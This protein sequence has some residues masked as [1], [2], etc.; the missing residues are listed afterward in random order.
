[1]G[2]LY[3]KRLAEANENPW[4]VEQALASQE[5]PECRTFE[6]GFFKG[7]FDTVDDGHVHKKSA[8]NETG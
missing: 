6:N 3:E 4:R 8:K 5:N 1:M 7:G 2:S